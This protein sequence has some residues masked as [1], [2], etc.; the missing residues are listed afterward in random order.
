MMIIISTYVYM[1]ITRVY[2]EK[3]N[4]T[5]LFLL[6]NFISYNKDTAKKRDSGAKK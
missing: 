2:I 3:A 1:Y 4:E 5:V 6:N